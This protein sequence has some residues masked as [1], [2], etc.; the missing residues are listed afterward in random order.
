MGRASW[1]LTACLTA[2]PRFVWEA[3]K[4][5]SEKVLFN[6]RL[7]G[8]EALSLMSTWGGGNCSR[9]WE[10]DT[11]L[12]PRLSLGRR[13]AGRKQ[14]LWPQAPG[15]SCSPRLRFSQP[16]VPY[17]L[18]L[19]RGVD[20]HDEGGHPR[21]GSRGAPRWRAGR[22]WRRSKE[23]RRGSEGRRNEDKPCGLRS[24]RRGRASQD[25]EIPRQFS[26]VRQ[27]DPFFQAHCRKG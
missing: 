23:A 8:Q 11:D 18:A 6:L 16:C 19:E 1:G 27:W 9:K 3:G 21:W 17:V 7:E 25:V 5:F 13:R 24:G 14:I 26:S 10:Q 15:C 12:K 4:G 20:T 22:L 2:G